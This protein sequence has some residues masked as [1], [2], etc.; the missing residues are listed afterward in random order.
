MPVRRG[1]PS[2][3]WG[4]SARSA[5]VGLALRR[6]S[7]P[8]RL[9]LGLPPREPPSPKTGRDDGARTSRNS[10]SIFKQPARAFSQRCAA[11]VVCKGAGCAVSPGPHRREGAE[12]R[13]ALSLYPRLA[14]GL[15]GPPQEGVHASRD[16][17]AS[18]RSTAAFAGGCSHGSRHQP[19][20]AFLE[21]AFARA[22]AAS[23]SQSARSGARAESR[24]RP[25]ARLR[26][27]PAGAAP[28]PPSRRLMMTPSTSRVEELNHRI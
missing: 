21:P 1:H 18:R 23:S 28:A 8:A 7:A 26:T 15:R 25:S 20:A 17:S 22:N 10:D 9:A 3:F 12:R 4:G 5:G 24:S 19:R 11:P 14:A 27:S 6:E 13:E 16:A 2:P